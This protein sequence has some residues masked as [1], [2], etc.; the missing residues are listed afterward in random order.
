[1]TESKRFS[2]VKT[3]SDDLKIPEMPHSVPSEMR[4][5]VDSYLEVN[6]AITDYYF[7][8]QMKI[9]DERKQFAKDVQLHIDSL[10]AILLRVRGPI[11][12][13]LYDGLNFPIFEMTK[14]RTEWESDG[15]APTRDIVRIAELVLDTTLL[16][17]ASFTASGER[18]HGFRKRLV[19]MFA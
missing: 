1:M 17:T 19:G 16:A 13:D 9:S 15:M 3:L 11:H 18:T 12:S 7:N 14:L 6:N 8:T 10:A 2:D 5:L 4:S